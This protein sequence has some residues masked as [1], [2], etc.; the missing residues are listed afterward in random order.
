MT[1]EKSKEKS[2]PISQQHWKK[3]FNSLQNLSPIKGHRWGSFQRQFITYFYFIEFL[4]FL[5]DTDLDSR[6]E[7]VHGNVRKWMRWAL[8][9]ASVLVLLTFYLEII[10][11]SYAFEKIQKTKQI[12]QIY[13]LFTQIPQVVTSCKTMI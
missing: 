10:A 12:I 13:P 11:H 8:H 9:I 2:F 4:S 3:Y 5:K 1:C 7:C 6:P